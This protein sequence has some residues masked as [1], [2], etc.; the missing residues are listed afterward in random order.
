MQSGLYFIL[1]S[2]LRA[3]PRPAVFAERW[4][5]AEELVRAIGVLGQ[6]CMRMWSQGFQALISFLVCF[7]KAKD[8][9]EKV[10]HINTSWI[11]EDKNRFW[12]YFSKNWGHCG[13]MTGWK[14]ITQF[15]SFSYFFFFFFFSKWTDRSLFLIHHTDW[16]SDSIFRFWCL[17]PQGQGLASTSGPPCPHSK[18]FTDY[19]TKEPNLLNLVT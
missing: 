5:W 4:G 18:S 17:W 1:S 8:K 15:F 19:A 3:A 13:L 10:W 2:E 14:P 11:S 12:L 7:P 9:G 6:R 16:V